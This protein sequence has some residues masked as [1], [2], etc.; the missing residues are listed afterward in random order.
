M[1]PSAA[2]RSFS[3]RAPAMAT[4]RISAGSQQR[5]FSPNAAPAGRVAGNSGSSG[6]QRFNGNAPAANPSAGR[7]FGGAQAPQRFQSVPPGAG[8]SGGARS[9]Q[10]APPIVRQ[11]QGSYA[12][13][14]P[15][16]SAPA[17]RAP[18]PSYRAAPQAPA[19]SMQRSALAPAQRSAPAP[20]RPS[21]GGG[22]AAPHTSGGHGGG[23][24]R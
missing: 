13:P 23:G 19:P 10:V 18:A 22:G 20:S 3:N 12:A 4:P 6:W 17:Y 1:S 21:G 2:N 7:Q 14:S 8:N 9:L 11:R 15:S 24:R 5:F 16:Y